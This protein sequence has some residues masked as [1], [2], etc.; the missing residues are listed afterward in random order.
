MLKADYGF[1]FATRR[2]SGKQTVLIHQQP[3]KAHQTAFRGSPVVDA[4][5]D[6]AWHGPYWQMTVQCGFQVNRLRAAPFIAPFEL[7]FLAQV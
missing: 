1:L 2:A 3:C 4:N 7:P 6:A 5:I